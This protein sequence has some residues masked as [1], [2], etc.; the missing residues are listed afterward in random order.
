MPYVPTHMSATGV[1]EGQEVISFRSR[2]EAVEVMDRTFQRVDDDVKLG[3]LLRAAG[4]S[5]RLVLPDLDLS[6]GLEAGR[7]RGCLE[8]SFGE[9]ASAFEPRLSL[10]MESAVANSMLQGAESIGVAIARRRIEVEGDARA[11]LVHL[12]ATRLISGHYRALLEGEYPHLL[13]RP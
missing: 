7:G 1:L 4:L 2:E 12:P 11:A 8:W 10:T 9:E 3:P 5:E 13:V 6:V